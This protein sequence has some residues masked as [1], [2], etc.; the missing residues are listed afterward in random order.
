MEDAAGRN[1]GR[2]EAGDRRPRNTCAASPPFASIVD[3]GQRAQ[4]PSGGLRMVDG[5]YTMK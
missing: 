5:R 2:L 4:L 1:S 3:I